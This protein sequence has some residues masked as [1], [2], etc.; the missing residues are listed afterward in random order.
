MTKQFLDVVDRIYAK[1]PLQKKRLEIY[2]AG[3]TPAF[4][5]EADEF[6]LHYT[7]FL[8]TCGISMDYAVDAYLKM[9]SN[10]LRCQV[11]FMRTGRYPVMSSD[12]INQTVYSSETEMLSYMVGLGISQF[13]W[14]TH[15]QIY[16]FFG[17]VI[18][19]RSEHISDYLEIGPG[20][21]L[22]LEKA[23]KLMGQLKEAVAIDISPTSLALTQAI[24][25]HSMPEKNN[26]RFVLG[27]ILQMDFN[28]QFDFITMGEVLEHVNQPTLLL[29]RLKEMLSQD[30]YAFISTCANCPAIDHV[31]QFDTVDQIRDLIHSSGLIIEK[32]LPLPVEAMS[33]V[34]A[35]CKKITINYCALVR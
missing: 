26:V 15:Y 11:D 34:E 23:L 24:I 30:G 6:V 17:D 29:S 9:C 5:A 28:K 25:A 4:F 8:T 7:D 13:L 16:S 2:L 32:E 1:S 21:G 12:Q 3:R 20:H 35:E 31:S 22:L 14:G 19:E 18:R 27:D 33:V 10:M